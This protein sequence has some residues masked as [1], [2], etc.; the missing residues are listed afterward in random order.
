MALQPTLTPRSPSDQ[1][2]VL[3]LEFKES[4][5]PLLL[6]LSSL[7]Y[8]LE[9]VH[10]LS[11]ML[12][13]D[14]Y[15]HNTLATPFFFYRKGRPL[16]PEHMARVARITKQ[17]PLALEII[18]AAVGGLWILVQTLEKVSNW[19]FDRQKLRLEVEK[20]RIENELKRLELD[21]KYEERSERR[22]AT[23]IQQQLVNR[24]EQ[25]E[26][27]LVKASVSLPD[28]EVTPISGHRAI[29]E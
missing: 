23:Q 7:L 25:S 22:N 26:F 21:E 11:V 24:L 13:Y 5:H 16:L 14:E 17:S 28:S 15:A 2:V 9:L 8:D 1:P 27:Q 4:K 20:L 6:S 3:R 19:S 10:D 18:V 29:R 12:T